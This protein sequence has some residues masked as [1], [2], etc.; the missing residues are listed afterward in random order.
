M[1]GHAGFG[2][3]QAGKGGLLDRRVAIPAVQ[4]QTGGMMLVA[5]WDRLRQRDI[6]LSRIGRAINGVDDTPKPEEPEEYSQ[7][8]HA[9]EAVAAFS[10]NLRH[11]P[12]YPAP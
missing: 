9:S 1:A 8:R 10:K 12:V 3:R 11:V 2:G 4:A 7:Q 6:L 5:E